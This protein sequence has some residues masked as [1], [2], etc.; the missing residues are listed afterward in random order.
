VLTFKSEAFYEWSQIEKLFI[1]SDHVYED[2]TYKAL[3]NNN[4]SKEDILY[5]QDL[6]FMEAA[7]QK[8]HLDIGDP[9]IKKLIT[10]PIFISNEKF[11]NH[12]PRATTLLGR[13]LLIDELIDNKNADQLI[14][15]RMIEAA[16]KKKS[17]DE[18]RKNFK[19]WTA[20]NEYEKTGY[21]L[22]EAGNKTSKSSS[23]FEIMSRKPI[24]FRFM[25]IAAVLLIGLVIWQPNKMSDEQLVEEF[26]HNEA[27]FDNIL[28]EGILTS[29]L[30]NGLRGN[31]FIFEGLTEKESNIAR[32]A[33][34]LIGSDEMLLAKRKLIELQLE[35]KGNNQLLF[36]LAISQA[37]TGEENKA[38]NRFVELKKV[39]KFILSEDVEFQ[40]AMLFLKTEDQNRSEEILKGISQKD[41]KYKDVAIKI[42]SKMRW[43]KL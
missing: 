16:L 5:W 19:E 10:H 38:I 4:E 39:E 36:F 7:E 23:E 25:T 31:E 21:T 28:N 34:Y 11:I 29:V 8:E 35:D 3:I 2:L 1:E 37:Y 18:L 17:R 15:D 42:L 20:E 30:P 40:L 9:S 33:V 13:E 14:P 41:G 6:F 24:Y 32:E 26:A 22:Q 43:F 27:V 12:L